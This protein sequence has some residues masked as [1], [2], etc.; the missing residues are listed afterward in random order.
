MAH[1]LLQMTPF[2]NLVISQQMQRMRNQKCFDACKQAA[3]HL[4]VYQ[5]QSRDTD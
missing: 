2:D 4:A 1:L 5:V 3:V